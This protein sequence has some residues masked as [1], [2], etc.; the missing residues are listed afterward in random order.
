MMKL[1]VP[2]QVPEPP[3]LRVGP[4]SVLVAEPLRDRP[5]LALITPVPLIVLPAQVKRPLTV[6]VPG[7][8]SVPRVWV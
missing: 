1:P 6:T 3:S 4:S 7:P 2:V 5:P 8:L